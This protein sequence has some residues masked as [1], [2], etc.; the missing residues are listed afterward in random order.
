MEDDRPLGFGLFRVDTGNECLWHGK[1]RITLAP[2]AFAVLCYLLE[3]P[4]RVVR[5]EEFFDAIWPK[6]VVSDIALAVCI[7]EIRK[8]VGDDSRVPR[9]IET[10]HRRGYRFLPSVMT[11]PPVVSNQLSV[12]SQNTEGRGKAELETGHGKL[13][14]R[15]VGRDS[16]LLQLHRWLD[17]ALEGERQ[18]LFIMGEPGIGKTTLVEAFLTQVAAEGTAWIGRGQCIEHYGA[19]EAYLPILEALGRLCREPDGRRVHTILGRYAPTWLVQMPSFLTNNAL[20]ALQQQVAGA[21]KT[22]MLRELAEAIEV[23]TAE[24]PLVLRL[25]DLHWSDVSTL[26][27]LAF[28]AR[29]TEHARL[30]ILGT[31]RPVEVL[32]REHPLKAVKQELYLHGHCQELPLGFLS[33]AAVREYLEVRFAGEEIGRATLRRLARIIH[34]RTDGNPLFMVNMVNHLLTHDVIVRVG[35]RV[36]LHSEEE[37][38]SRRVPEDLRQMIEQ[39]LAQVTPAERAVLAV[40]SVAGA[41]FSAAAVAAGLETTVEEVEEQCGELARQEL[42]L[43]VRGTAD[44]PDRTVATRYGFLHALYQEVLYERLPAGRRQRLHQRIG[45]REE[46]GYGE[47]VGEIAAELAAH[48]EQGRNYRKAVQYLQQ[49]GDNAVR[50]SAHQEA[51]SLLTKG[52]ELLKSWPDTPERTQQELTLQIALGA[53]LQAAKGYGAPEVEKTYARARELCR[54][55]GE[56]ALIFPVL[57]GLWGFYFMRAE[58]QTALALGQEWLTLAQRAQDPAFLLGAHY[59]LGAT[60]YYLGEVPST[61]VHLEQGIA[62]YDLQQH[63]SQAFAYGHDSGVACLSYAALSLGFLGYPDQALKKS[64]EALALAQELAHPNTLAFAL[65]FA[66]NFHSQRREI[67]LVAERAEAAITLAI[68]QGLPHWAWHGKIWRGM[69]LLAEQGQTEEAIDRVQ[70][71]LADMQAL[72]ARQGRPASLALLAVAYAKAEQMEKAL[73]TVAEALSFM[74]ETGQRVYEVTLYRLKGEL[75]LTQEGKSQKAKGKSQ[76]SKTTDPRP[77]TPDPQGEAEA[78]FLQAI[79]VARKQQAK[80]LELQAVMSLSRLWQ[81]QGKH[82]AAHTLLSEIYHWFTEGF[83]TKDLQEAKALLD[84]LESRVKS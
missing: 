19:G 23:I 60:S 15:L 76:K 20:K 82:H 18:V 42:F 22:R 2:K 62:L 13:T 33:E 54:Q 58:E 44:W 8:A 66:A 25:E 73:R 71:G 1:Q 70:Q 28:V 12:V 72:G 7:R 48:F 79:K 55:I 69:L 64:R 9:F 6:T 5:K 61:L 68:E 21:T 57:R 47:Q 36:V 43:R 40:A 67:H 30:L 51:I 26:D 46:K 27:W 77:L 11:T 63:R 24:R 84:N 38:V 41:E 35:G 14:T 83:D 32:M 39:R 37:E 10:V 78:C 34:Q 52:L 29:R 50:R 56:T 45:E 74:E 49:A 31:Y 80:S 53:S 65:N 59:A 16:E 75:L 3:H 17:Q 81:R 4:G